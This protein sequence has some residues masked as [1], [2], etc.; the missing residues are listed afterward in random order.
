MFLIFI[1]K[2]KTLNKLIQLGIFIILNF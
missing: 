2:F 1:K